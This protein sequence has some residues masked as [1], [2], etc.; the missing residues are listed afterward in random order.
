MS[1][2]PCEHVLANLK[3]SYLNLVKRIISYVSGTLDYGLWYPYDTSL[4]ISGY[5]N[6]D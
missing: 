3:D 4:M 1:L 6:V 5:S 2:I